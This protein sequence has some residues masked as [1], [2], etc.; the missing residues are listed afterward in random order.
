MP[1]ASCRGGGLLMIGGCGLLTWAVLG[2]GRPTGSTRTV[3]RFEKRGLEGLRGVEEL[4][5]EEDEDRRLEQLHQLVHL[6][7]IFDSIGV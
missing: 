2:R 7:F 4:E 1:V 3:E 5:A 6:W